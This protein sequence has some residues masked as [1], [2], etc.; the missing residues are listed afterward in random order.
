MT[1]ER[2]IESGLPLSSAG[3]GKNID[4]GE[5]E[6]QFMIDL[7]IVVVREFI[8]KLV[9]FALLHKKG[10]AGGRRE[11][12]KTSEQAAGVEGKRREG[13]G[14]KGGNRGKKRI[15]PDEKQRQRIPH[16]AT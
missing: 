13:K 16:F 10:R 12:R 14:R 6:E 15:P 4:M 9:F 5:P 7:S 1:E 3:E 11:R 8:S 2:K